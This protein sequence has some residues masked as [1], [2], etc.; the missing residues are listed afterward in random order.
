M[1][2]KRVVKLIFRK[3]EILNFQQ[4]FDSKKDYIIKQDGCSHLQLLQDTK[5]E[6]IHFTISH[7]DCEEDLNRYRNSD[8]FNETWKATK[9]LFDE[10]PEAWSLNLLNMPSH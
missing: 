8:L 9:A 3:E 4:I 10:K 1:A 6:R 7:W 5:D 2:I